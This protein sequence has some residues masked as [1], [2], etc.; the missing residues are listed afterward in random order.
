MRKFLTILSAVILGL[1]ITAGIFWASGKNVLDIFKK[2][3]APVNT[4]ETV[5]NTEKP[6]LEV[7]NLTY[8]ARITKGDEYFSQGA[9]N[10][11]ATEYSKA[12]LLQPD[13]VSTYLKLTQTHLKLRNFD[14]A[15][16]NAQAVLKKDPNN[17]EALSD[18]ILIQVKLSDFTNAQKLIETL[19]QTISQTAEISYYKGLLNAISNNHDLAKTHLNQA[20]ALNDAEYTPKID[21]ILKSY[22]AFEAAQAGEELY[23]KIL[24]AKSLNENEEYEM[25]IHILK[26]VLKARSDLRDGW[27]LLGFA[28]LNLQNYQFALTAFDKAY[29]LDPTWSTTQYFLGI[30]HKELSH[31]NEAIKYFTAALKGDFEAKVVIQNHLADLY[32]QAKDYKK[33]TEAY[34]DVLK[35]NKGDLNAFVRPIWLYLD[36]LNQPEKALA[37]AK[38]AL[39]SFPDAAMSYNL[40]GWSYIGMGDYKNAEANLKRSLALDPKLAAAHLNLGQLNE[41]WGKNDLALKSYQEAYKI[42]QQGS[43]GNMAGQKYNALIKEMLKSE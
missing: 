4:P 17:S 2:E 27:I 32:F 20:K 15:L 24:L 14:K 23:L 26:E 10:S 39:A 25:S 30:T 28:Y 12:A 6:K 22:E 40:L 35:V 18:Q 9:Y 31:T 11:A 36:Y 19:P 3:T 13:Q 41:K 16:A 29:S 34:E 1:L 7:V 5:K 43:I 37:L 8:D 21:R 33:A 38:T 42:D